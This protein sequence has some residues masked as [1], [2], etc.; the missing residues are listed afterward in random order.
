MENPWKNIE[1]KTSDYI[2]DC[3]KSVKKIYDKFDLTI[4]PQPYMGDPINSEIFLLNGNP[5]DGGSHKNFI[6][7]HREIVIKNLKHEITDYPLYGINNEFKGYFIF[8]WW[9]EKIFP[10]INVVEDAKKVSKNIFV[11][12]YLPYFRDRYINGL[13]IPS[14]KYTFDIVDKAISDGKI[15]IIMRAKRDW[16]NS[17]PKLKDYKNKF[18]LHNPQNVI[19]SQKNLDNGVF[20]KIIERIK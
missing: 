8:K 18:V 14:Q 5:N 20:E 17:L 7:D 15:I 19:I 1:N 3:D 10:I 9:Q 6:L 4:I 12:E 16:E 13:T 11:A 2:A